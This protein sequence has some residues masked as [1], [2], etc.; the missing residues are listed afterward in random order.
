MQ[1]YKG[2]S[3]FPKL[4]APVLT[5]GSFDGVHVGH[6]K[7]LSRLVDA[8]KAINGQVVLLTFDPHPRKIL[9]PSSNSVQLLSTL[10]EKIDLLSKY[11][12]EH[13]V[14]QPFTRDFSMM[15]HDFFIRELL[16]KQI[17]VKK[18][19]IGYDHQFGHN[20]SGSFKE[21]ELLAPSFGF[22]VEEIP[23]QDINDSAVSSTRIRKA[24]LEGNIV[25][26]SNLL[27]YDYSFTGTV[28]KGNQIGRTLG[29]PT[30][31]LLSHDP[32]KL[33]PANG[34]YAVIV[35]VHGAVFK[36]VLSIGTRPTFDNGARSVEVNIFKFNQDIYG[37]ECTVRFK[38]F[39][40]PELKF[41]GVDELVVAMKKDKE[42][43]LELLGGF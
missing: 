5:L 8:A 14:V 6:Q 23:E 17:G 40:R 33:V 13:L 39:I 41:N 19:V 34:V 27:G 22:E 21:L 28:V 15:E 12:V 16:V 11:G 32:D 37:E 3:A 7:I 1:I 31:N 4:D 24:L 29:F 20:R 43:T 18:L 25:D 36:G 9:F 10:D 30:A 35:E 2:L 38:N 42:K 26:A